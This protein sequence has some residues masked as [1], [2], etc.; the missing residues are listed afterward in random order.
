MKCK[1]CCRSRALAMPTSA[2]LG[3]SA[4]GVG[5]LGNAGLPGSGRAHQEEQLFSVGTKES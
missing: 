4:A 3:A 2:R 5:W 1:L